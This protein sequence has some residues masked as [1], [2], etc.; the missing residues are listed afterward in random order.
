LLVP[1][2]ILV[3]LLIVVII[4]VIL[5]FVVNRG[6]IDGRTGCFYFNTRTASKRRQIVASRLR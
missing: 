2:F 1:V 3:A 4:V 5:I 6:Y